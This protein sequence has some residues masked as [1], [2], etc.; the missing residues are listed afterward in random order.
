[1]MV[2]CNGSAPKDLQERPRSGL[3]A[4]DGKICPLPGLCLSGSCRRSTL[5]LLGLQNLRNGAS[6]AGQFVVLDDDHRHDFRPSS[7]VI[8]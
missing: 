4:T 7:L 1:M 8:L 5:S 6:H 3:R 2:A